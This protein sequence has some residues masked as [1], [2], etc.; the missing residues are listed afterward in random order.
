MNPTYIDHVGKKRNGYDS[1]KTCYAKGVDKLTKS[2]LRHLE[3][4]ARTFWL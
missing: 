4:T 2:V 3:S 1:I